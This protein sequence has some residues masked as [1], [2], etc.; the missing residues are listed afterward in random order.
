V[1]ADSD[2]VSDIETL[3]AHPSSELVRV[4]Q[5]LV[6]GNVAALIVDLG[7]EHGLVDNDAIGPVLQAVLEE[8]AEV[9]RCLVR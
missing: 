7:L 6:V 3:L 4:V 2:L 8:D 9:C 1:A 5:Q